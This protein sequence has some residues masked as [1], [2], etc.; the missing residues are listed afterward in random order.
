KIYT[1]RL[2]LKK[3]KLR[4]SPEYFSFALFFRLYILK[5]DKKKYHT[6]NFSMLIVLILLITNFAIGHPILY[7]YK[8]CIFTDQDK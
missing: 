2:G 3:M 5:N 1:P 6:I 8:S 7:Y 4:Y